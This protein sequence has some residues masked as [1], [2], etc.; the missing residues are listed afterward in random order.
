MNPSRVG[1]V[2]EVG[3]H[4]PTNDPIESPQKTNL[5]GLS[6]TKM[7]DFFVAMG[8]KPFRAQQVLQWIHQ[9]GVDDI[10]QMT[11]ISQALR[12]RLMACAVILAPTIVS[13]H[14]SVDGTRKWMIEIRPGQQVEAVWIPEGK[15]ATLCIS[16]QVGCILDCPFCS[17]GKQGFQRN[18]TAAEI[19]GQLWL[20][21]R[22]FD[23]FNNP[24][25]PTVSNVVMMG[26]GEPLLNVDNVI[27][28]IQLML[29]DLAYGLSKR[30]VT[31][32]T[33]GV[34]PA[35]DQ[36]AEQTDVSLAIS[37]HA[38]NDTLRNT[39]VPLN[40]RYPIAT[41]LAAAQR[42]I[43]RQSDTR[44]VVTIEYILLEDINDSLDLAQE[45]AQLLKD[46]PC[47]IN[48]IP[49]NAFPLSGFSRPSNNRIHRFAH[50]LTQA[51]FITTIRKTRGDDIDA[52][53]GQL[54]GQFADKPRRKQRYQQTVAQ[55]LQL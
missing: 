34:V 9:H 54:V 16:S 46:F 40:R 47:K 24:Q 50:H 53:C 52:A 36:L 19:I 3:K 2:G 33:A 23:G 45:L 26:M 29:N 14:D 27:D 15:R 49:F 18:L 20:A 22:S 43:A 32:S 41:L 31:L 1:K 21:I 28:A 13:Q 38:P 30:R 48:L 37:L 17:T 4:N 5:L 7:V 44:R 6:P 55:P 8:E 25:T 35:L 39:L 12:S 42:Y 10:S 11:N 51:G